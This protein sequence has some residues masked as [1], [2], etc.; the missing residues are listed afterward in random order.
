MTEIAAVREHRP[1]PERSLITAI[2][3][4]IEFIF[5][6]LECVVGESIVANIK[7]PPH[8]YTIIKVD[9]LKSPD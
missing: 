5:L 7:R 4:V 1:K 9:I 6:M 3:L 8:K 2:F